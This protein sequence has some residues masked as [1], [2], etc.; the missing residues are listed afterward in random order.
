[1]GTAV[2][3]TAQPQRQEAWKRWLIHEPRGKMKPF[4]KQVA[5]SL[6]LRGGGVGAHSSARAL[7]GSS[8]KTHCAPSRVESTRVKSCAGNAPGGRQPGGGFLDWVM[9]EECVKSWY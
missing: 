5:L 6:P 9:D 3:V 8:G 1:M 7:L 4:R 2:S